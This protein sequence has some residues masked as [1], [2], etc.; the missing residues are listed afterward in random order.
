MLKDGS[1]SY[2]VKKPGTKL[3]SLSFSL[4]TYTQRFQIPGGVIHPRGGGGSIPRKI[5]W[6]CAAASQNPCPIYDQ[7]LRFSTP[8]LIKT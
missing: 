3:S 7:N 2:V 4:T 8:Y 5:G 1:V 6:G